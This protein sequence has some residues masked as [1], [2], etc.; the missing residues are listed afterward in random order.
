MVIGDFDHDFQEFERFVK[1]IPNLKCLSIC[2]GVGQNILD[3]HRWECLITSSLPQLETFHFR[4]SC[5]SMDADDNILEIFQRF[6]SD[7]W[8]RAHNWHTECLLTS[9]NRWICTIPCPLYRCKLAV[10]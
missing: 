9:D 3:A 4:F 6:Q 2:S 5:D 7:F 1:L 8:H 10:Y